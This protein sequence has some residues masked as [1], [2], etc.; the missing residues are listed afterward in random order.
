M[1]GYKYRNSV[2]QYGERRDN[3]TNDVQVKDRRNG[4]RRLRN[5]FTETEGFK[6]HHCG[7][8]TVL[9]QARILYYQGKRSEMPFPSIRKQDA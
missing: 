6:G 9:C 2:S 5:N 8:R 7:L 4:S 1:R 3:K